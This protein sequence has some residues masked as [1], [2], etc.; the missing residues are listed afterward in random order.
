MITN[1]NDTESIS[2][3]AQVDI[4]DITI[5]EIALREERACA[6]LCT[7]NAD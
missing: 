7:Y 2:E 5:E 6:C 1:K 4:E 3:N